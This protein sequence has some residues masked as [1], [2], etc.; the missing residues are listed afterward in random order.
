[1]Y[2]DRR[3]GVVFLLQWW[4]SGIDDSLRTCSTTSRFVSDILISKGPLML[5]GAG[6]Y[7]ILVFLMLMESHRLW[8]ASERRSRL[9]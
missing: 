3:Y 1:M 5:P 2:L 6:W 9:V 7:M 8:Y 4:P